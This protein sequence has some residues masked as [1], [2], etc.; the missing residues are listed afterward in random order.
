[1]PKIPDFSKIDLQSIINSVK[2][3][4][5]PD[6]A[7]P[8]VSEGDPIGTKIVEISKLLQGVASSQA[9]SA[10]D[11]GKINGLLNNLYQDLEAFRKL[12]SEVKSKERAETET[13][14]EHTETTVKQSN[15]TTET[16][17]KNNTK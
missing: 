9:Q 17:H 10:K 13:H 12:E 6:S 14:P 7:T 2:T 3:V 16:L 15:K 5:S 4:L 11:L 1:M 8:N